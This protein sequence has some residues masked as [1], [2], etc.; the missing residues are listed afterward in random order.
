MFFFSLSANFQKL[1]IPR[2]FFA[3]RNLSFTFP[4]LYTVLTSIPTTL[5]NKSIV[6]IIREILINV[7]E[8]NDITK[9][10]SNDHRSFSFPKRNLS[11]VSASEPAETLRDDT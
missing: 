9:S 6:H 11:L 10:S 4:R 2:L 3:A 8:E 1:F 5:M 7:V